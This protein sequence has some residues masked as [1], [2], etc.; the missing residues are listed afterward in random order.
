[1]IYV[2]IIKLLHLE[3]M[4]CRGSR[5]TIVSELLFEH[6]RVEEVES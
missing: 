1:M 5:V 2:H 4:N 6:A 3:H